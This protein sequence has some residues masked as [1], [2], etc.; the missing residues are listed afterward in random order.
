MSGFLQ[1]LAMVQQDVF[2]TGN[3]E[4]TFFK[5]NTDTRL[6]KAARI[7]QKAFRAWR[8]RKRDVAARIIQRNCNNWIDKPYTADGKVGISA[9]IG[10]RA[11][12]YNPDSR[13]IY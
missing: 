11:H 7:I 12:G 4:I 9:R 13:F 8:F 10:L 1:I 6:H 3:P 2:L 5:V